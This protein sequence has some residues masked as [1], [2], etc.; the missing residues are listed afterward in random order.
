M[1]ITLPHI[2]LCSYYNNIDINEIHAAGFFE[3]VMQQVA[4]RFQGFQLSQFFV[5]T[6]GN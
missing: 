5:M 2:L 4:W 6:C 3:K 1:F